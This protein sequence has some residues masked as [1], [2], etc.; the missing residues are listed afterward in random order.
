MF[1]HSKE[2]TWCCGKGVWKYCTGDCSSLD[3]TLSP[4]EIAL[5]QYQNVLH[6]QLGKFH[7]WTTKQGRGDFC[8]ESQRTVDRLLF[9]VSVL[10]EVQPILQQAVKIPC[11]FYMNAINQQAQHQQYYAHVLQKNNIWFVQE[12]HLGRLCMLAIL[13]EMHCCVLV[14]CIPMSMKVG[15][16]FAYCSISPWW[17]LVGRWMG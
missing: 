11:T 4:T 6:L 8:F 3:S 13:V 9:K 15:A 16:L 17:L 10:L 2:G 1:Q 12:S 14:S 7:L 5:L